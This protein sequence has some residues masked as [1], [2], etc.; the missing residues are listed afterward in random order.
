MI[1]PSVLN[2]YASRVLVDTALIVAAGIVFV[3]VVGFLIYWFG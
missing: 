3:Y 1:P 2:K